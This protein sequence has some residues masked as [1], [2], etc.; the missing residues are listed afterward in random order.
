[1]NLS[2]L[3]KTPNFEEVISALNMDNIPVSHL[4]ENPEKLDSTIRIYISK[5]YDKW[6]LDKNYLLSKLSFIDVDSVGKDI[7]ANLLLKHFKDELSVEKIVSIVCNNPRPI[8][9]SILKD[10]FEGKILSMDEVRI[11]IDYH[12]DNDIGLYNYLCIFEGNTVINID[13][14]SCFELMEISSNAASCIIGRVVLKYNYPSALFANIINY[15]FSDSYYCSFHAAKILIKFYKSKLKLD[16]LE[17]MK[18]V[19]A[20]NRDSSDLD[21]INNQIKK[22]TPNEEVDRLMEQIFSE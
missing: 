6:Q 12:K 2:L 22:K 1:M 19:C 3:E 13:I 10:A 17:R 11:I 14:H 8:S 7:C 5:E 18:M 20:K 4:I 21:K 15:L 16:H 9:Q